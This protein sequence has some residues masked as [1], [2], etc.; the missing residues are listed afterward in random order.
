M[1]DM[2]VLAV[3]RRAAKK[4]Q[5]NI[6]IQLIPVIIT[7]IVSAAA[8]ILAR[9]YEQHAFVWAAGDGLPELMQP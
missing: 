2:K 8:L 5:N 3:G 9:H 1:G 7:F 4:M 6:E